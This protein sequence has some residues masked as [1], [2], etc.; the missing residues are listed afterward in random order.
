M[1][2]GRRIGKEAEESEDRWD[3]GLGSEIGA[4]GIGL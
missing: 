3:D 2:A 1:M 4:A